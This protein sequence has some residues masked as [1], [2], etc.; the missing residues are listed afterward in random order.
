M[1]SLIFSSAPFFVF[2]H[3][4]QTA[5][6]KSKSYLV[7]TLNNTWV[8]IMFRNPRRVWRDTVSVGEQFL[9]SWTTHPTTH[10]I[11]SHKTQISS[12]I[13]MRTL[14]LAASHMSASCMM[15]YNTMCWSVNCLVRSAFFCDFTD[16][17]GQ[18]PETSVSNY[19]S[20]LHK[21]PEQCRFLLH[22]DG[23]LQLHSVCR[24]EMSGKFR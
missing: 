7:Y 19:H 16:A 11:K 22:R 18:I 3:K 13:T 8:S 9:M 2:L 21:I 20:T 15:V 4:C 12:N 1:Y 6:L 17:S 10:S 24:G 23:S 14:D 5:C